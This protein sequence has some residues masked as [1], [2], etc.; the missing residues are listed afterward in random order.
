M[1][2]SMNPPLNRKVARNR[3]LRLL[4]LL[5]V[6]GLGPAACSEGFLLFANRFESWVD[7]PFPG[8]SGL[9][10]RVRGTVEAPVYDVDGVTRVAGAAYLAQL[11]FVDFIEHA[12][13]VT[14]PTNNWI[15]LG[16]PAPFGTGPNAG[17][18]EL[19]DE[20]QVV[21]TGPLKGGI[22][23]VEL[24]VWE[25]SKGRTFEQ[26]K[27]TGG[28]IG[29]SDS[30]TVVPGTREAPAVLERLRPIQLWPGAVIKTFQLD[31]ER[32]VVALHEEL[33]L[34]LERSHYDA[35]S[36][37]E[38][39][40]NGLRL[41][42]IDGPVLYRETFTAEDEGIYFV[43]IRT[44]G[45]TVETHRCIV[46]R[47]RDGI[48]DSVVVPA[49][50][51]VGDP[52]RLEALVGGHGAVK[53]RWTH[54]DGTRQRVISEEEKSLEDEPVRVEL[55]VPSAELGTYG[56]EVEG[57]GL[58]HTRSLVQIEGDFQVTRG[59]FPQGG[60]LVAEPAS[61]AGYVRGSVVTLRVILPQGHVLD[62]WTGDL[63][64]SE[65]PKV[66]V[67]DR[68]LTVGAVLRN[69]SQGALPRAILDRE[70]TPRA[71]TLGQPMRVTATVRG[72]KG[73]ITVRWFRQIGPVRLVD[74]EERRQRDQES[75]VVEF[76]TQQA[77]YGHHYLEAEWG[78]GAVV[79]K[80]LAS[81]R[82]DVS[83]TSEHPYGS[84]AELQPATDL[85][86]LRGSSV[87][88]RL[89]CPPEMQ[90]VRWIGDLADRGSENPTMVILDRSKHAVF[91]FRTVMTLISIG[92]LRA[93]VYD[94][95]RKLVG[96]GIVGQ[97][98][99]GASPEAMAPLGTPTGIYNGGLYDWTLSSRGFVGLP[100]V[101][102]GSSAF[103]Q[104]RVWEE[105]AGSS[106]ADA[107]ARGG[108]HGQ[109]AIREFPTGG[110]IRFL[111]EL[112]PV[113]SFPSIFLNAAP[114][115]GAMERTII[116][117]VGQDV[118]FQAKLGGTEPMVVRW[119]KDGVLLPSQTTSVLQIPGAK[120][121]DQGVYVISASN[122]FG[123][124]DSP[125]IQL[126]MVQ[127]PRIRNIRIS[128]DPR[129][130][131]PLRIEVDATSE[132]TFGSSWLING[133]SVLAGPNVP[134]LDLA[135]APAGAYL[136][137]LE[138]TAGGKLETNLLS[139]APRYRLSRVV[140]GDGRIV[141][142]PP[143]ED[144]IYPAGTRVTLEAEPGTQQEFVGW[145]GD[146]SGS[147]PRIEILADRDK[148]V[149]AVFA[150]S[151]GSVFAANR[152][153]G[154]GGID[155]PIFDVDGVTRLEGSDFRVQLFAGPLPGALEPIAD[156]KEFLT[157]AGAG[158][159]A[160]S[161]QRFPTVSPGAEG[162]VQVRAWEASAGATY[163]EA[164][165]NHGRSGA[166]TI[167]RVTTGGLGTPPSLPARLDG[168]TSFSLEVPSPPSVSAVIGPS[169]VADGDVL[170]LEASIAGTVPIAVQWLRNGEPIPGALDSVYALPSAGPTDSGEYSLRLENSM[171][172]VVSGI[173]G[174]AVVEP[175]GIRVWTEADR[176]LL[177]ETATL[178]AEA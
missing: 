45:R 105:A 6:A 62:H 139:L 81:V 117:G 119:R 25:A 151:G 37:I 165:R 150:G 23:L 52:F 116:A 92:E 46:E 58:R 169:T 178:N 100:G 44:P 175:R 101:A 69:E 65:N 21:G 146:W 164:V 163:D 138:N 57:Q 82:G 74:R 78:D 64:G 136:L 109:S 16:I 103:V 118:R 84:Y 2:G 88:L 11:Y 120:E 131:A 171:G 49:K 158:Y 126:R 130:R 123:S 86:Y 152:V 70:V 34:Q 143:A 166:S 66:V 61:A 93:T 68:N 170:R 18:V 134:A 83:L 90:F 73:P 76:E 26:A 94:E 129:A 80:D 5:W 98:H 22:A 20:A 4:L 3:W 125:P 9:P 155:A 1:M 89:V 48:V 132:S 97:L 113:A 156:P 176:I 85:D 33:R 79:R 17:F 38:W 154:L 54:F 60:I 67:M 75:V 91:E 56:V 51:A 10:E 8:P 53:I 127:P 35:G 161:T 115:F 36:T 124:A 172:T 121:S 102:P 47:R 149:R 160:G 122:E 39:F 137:I 144:D 14:N 133:K 114:A 106:W 99:A 42:G 168:L 27:A 41:P 107:K 28:W 24:R 71:P 162:W 147:S 112:R 32:R 40:R 110:D 95:F 108:R 148:S 43:R 63:S 13:P 31:F 29:K 167:L 96:P 140:E 142:D 19:V 59:G 157:G 111:S 15:A 177:G 87:L 153:S 55:S 145:F 72:G 30:L 135:E 12:H 173:H 174:V 141:A 77:Q 50:P 104:I 159:F 7:G 128:P